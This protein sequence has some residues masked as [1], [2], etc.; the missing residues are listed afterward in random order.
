[1]EHPFVIFHQ[2]IQGLRNKVNELLLSI[3]SVKPQII[4]LSEHHMKYDEINTLH[5]PSY[6]LS[7]NFSRTTLKC[8][9]V[10]IFVHNDIQFTNISLLNHNKEQDLEITAIKIKFPTKN[11]IVF[12]I[13]RAPS[14]D[15]DYFLCHIDK[16]LNH[17]YKP[18]TDFILCGDLNINFLEKNTNQTLLQNVLNTFNLHGTVHFPTRI[19]STTAKAIDNIFLDDTNHYIIKPHMNGLSDHDAQILM[20]ESGKLPPTNGNDNIIYTRNINEHSIREFKY[21]LSWELWEE[22][23]NT[24]DVNI[25]FNSFLNTYLQC[26]SSSFTRKKIN[27]SFQ[28]TQ[29][30]KGWITKG[31]KVSCM[32]K[33]KLYEISRTSR[34]HIL[35]LHY[36]KYCH[37]LSKVICNAKKLHYKNMILKSK[38][39]MKSTWKI[40]HNEKGRNQQYSTVSSLILDKITITNTATIANTFNNYFTSIADS[41]N[42]ANNNVSTS[43]RTN[44][45][46]YLHKFHGDNV[47]KLN[48]KPATTHEIEIIIRNMES[49]ESC[50]Y[51]EISSRILKLSL[52][53][54]I[55]PLTHIC[56]A[57]L[58]TG[59]F[60]NRLKYAIIKPIFKKGNKQDVSNYRPI[61]LLTTFSKVFEKI[62]YNRLYNHFEING[63]LS[64]EQFGFRK[65]H[66]IEQAAFSLINS[67]LTALNNKQIAGGIF[68]DLQ[69][70]FDCVNHR[71]LLEKL[72]FYGIHGKF[73]ALIE[74]YLT[75]RYQKVTLNSNTNM[76]SSSNWVKLRCGVPQGSIIGPLLFLIYINDL[77]S[78]VGKN[79]N[80]VLY[81]D[82]TSLTITDTNRDD[83][84]Y[85]INKMLKELDNWFDANL[86]KLNFHKTHYME[87]KTRKQLNY[88]VQVL[89]NSNCIINASVTK[90]LGLLIDETL[91]WNQHV[92]QLIK[93]MTTASYALRSVKHSLP[94]ET[95][96]IIYY[97]S[98]HSIMS[99]GIIFWGTAT[100][101]NK[102]FLTQKKILKIIYNIRPR[103]SSREIFKQNQIFTL[104]SQYIYSLLLFTIKNQ[105]LFTVNKSIYEYSTRNNNNLHPSLTN[106]TK[107]KNGP[108]AMCIKVYNHLP[109]YI[110]ETIHNPT[111]FR[112]RLK[113]FLHSHSFYSLKEF[114]EYNCDK[115]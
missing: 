26:L 101:A 88:N 20:I 113:S 11:V 66:T 61:S 38:N 25:M 107:V 115:S 16:L 23:F 112:N 114:Y 37:I 12:C 22:V 106:L 17:L 85:Q 5:I 52:P 54:I 7:A 42:I 51:D 70:A 6:K 46:D 109:Y 76:M 110:K 89:H 30:P 93:K 56:N 48:W 62:I 64:Q 40:I 55:S 77:P 50:G 43:N 105:H 65:Q 71:I 84:F 98:V 13:Y 67:T 15:M 35:K 104:Y 34:D 94:I 73:F 68:C 60:P 41:I 31:I 75:N 57:A 82:D 81:A 19:T 63:I 47:K 79:N 3:Y 78:I 18:K 49:K 1:M 72:R 36:K 4:C 80:I 10:C 44:P 58:N 69:K 39:K 92:Q 24:N 100:G 74:S 95:L 87:F 108:Y 32:T 45:I 14:G 96:K 97:A 91:T 86:L 27:T 2:N 9:G 53:F 33:Q 59:I 102:V 103:D 8:G 83:F 21:L 90:F 29:V 111:Q 99:Y 28:K